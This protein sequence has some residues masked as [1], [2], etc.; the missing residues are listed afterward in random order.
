MQQWNATVASGLVAGVAMCNFLR[1]SEI[2]FLYLKFLRQVK[3]IIN[4]N[5]W[6]LQILRAE[7][8]N[9]DNE[10]N[11]G[12]EDSTALTGIVH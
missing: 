4:F 8:K 2:M 5:V 7:M 1:T 3:K 11:V 9:Q 10:T 6:Q 12:Q